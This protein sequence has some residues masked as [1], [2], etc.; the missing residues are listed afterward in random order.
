MVAQS[1]CA[2][3]N[4]ANCAF[5]ALHDPESAAQ[6][7]SPHTA[8]SDSAH[9][10]KIVLSC[11]TPNQTYALLHSL[12]NKPPLGFLNSTIISHRRRPSTTTIK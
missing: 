4:C 2:L 12:T 6:R 3:R 8:L 1:T 10:L 9:T 5:C 7:H 11:T